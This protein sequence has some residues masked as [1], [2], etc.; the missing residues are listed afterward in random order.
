[1]RGIIFIILV[2][3][4]GVASAQPRRPA[5]PYTPP[6]TVLVYN[7]NENQ[8]VISNN[9]DVVRPMASITKL[10]TA[11]VVLDNF[12]LDDKVRINKKQEL[13]VEVLLTRLLVRSDNSA[14]EILAK[15]YPGGRDHFLRAMNDKAK[16]LGLEDT[17][18][19]DPSGLI[20]TN[21]ATA[22]DLAK[23]VAIAGNYDFI[24]QVSSKPE[25]EEV[26]KDKKKTVKHVLPNTNKRILS[27]FNHI[28]VSK[29]GFTSRAGRC[30][31]ML[32]EGRGYKYAIIILGEPSG[33]SREDMARNLLAMVTFNK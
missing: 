4:L 2:L 10:M 19:N 29:T 6:P 30:L 25:A 3:S 15:A 24:A 14:S 12:S 5:A 18:F 27:D 32:V 8:I 33:Q 31:A 28:L 9:A 17:Y 13:T 20:P 21:I 26:L 23:L 22:H 11:M 7:L 1:M 16:L